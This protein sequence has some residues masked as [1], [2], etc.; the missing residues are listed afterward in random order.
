MEQNTIKSE[1]E[2]GLSRRDFLKGMASV[3]VAAIV[4]P[5]TVE[6]QDVI[7]MD[8]IKAFI[9]GC[10]IDYKTVIPRIKNKKAFIKDFLAFKEKYEFPLPHPIRQ[11][12]ESDSKYIAKLFDSFFLECLAAAKKWHKNGMPL[13]KVDKQMGGYADLFLIELKKYVS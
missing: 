9:E 4:A 13:I 3:A 2:A 8:S 10:R 11:E 7:T 12:N 5:Q 6:A 1:P